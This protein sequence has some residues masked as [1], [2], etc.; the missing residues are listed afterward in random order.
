M[1]HFDSRGR[2]SSKSVT[3]TALTSTPHGS[4]KRR[5]RCPKRTATDSRYLERESNISRMHAS[6]LRRLSV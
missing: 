5:L 6:I 2:Y 1:R 3:L 4:S